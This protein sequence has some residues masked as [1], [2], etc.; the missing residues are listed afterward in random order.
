V[1][2]AL[3]AG[4][5]VAGGAWLLTA[6]FA[7][8][9]ILPLRLFHDRAF[10]IPTAIS[11]LIG[12]ALFGTISYLP[13]Y[14][15]IALGTSATSA[16]LVLTCLMAGVLITMIA[17]GRLITRT[18]RYRRYPIVGTAT[19]TLGLALLATIGPSGPAWPLIV[20]IVLIG[21]GVGL[22]MQVMMLVAQNGVGH[23]DLGAAT[24]AVTFLRQIGASVGV[25]VIGAMITSRFTGRLPAG[26][27]DQLPGGAGALSAD[28]A[29]ALPGDVRD[30]IAT[31]FGTA[32][33][34]VF[35][36]VAPVLGLA[37]LLAL[38]LP[39]RPLRDTAHVD[40]EPTHGRTS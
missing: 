11:F 2:P 8:D 29:A 32:V 18:G 20:F 31:A 37:F 23:A 10:A 36:S 33:P 6:R 34:P 14:L 25:A 35:G 9:P 4:V 22:T 24:S 28:G 26:V 16:G 5:A 38:L 39:E 15:Q 17:S 13:A 30:V 21:L 19:A 40:A 1:T 27:A 3:A 7:R 12:F